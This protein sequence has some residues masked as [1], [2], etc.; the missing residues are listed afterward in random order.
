[1]QSLIFISKKLRK[2]LKI[3]HFNLLINFKVSGGGG[4]EHSDEVSYEIVETLGGKKH[5]GKMHKKKKHKKGYKKY[6]KNAT[7]IILCIIAL[8]MLLQH[9]II[10]KLAALS[11]LST[12][13]S[14]ASFLLSSLLALKQMM[15]S[16][17]HEKS[18]SGGKLEVVHIPIRKKHPDFHDRDTEKP[19]Y[20]PLNYP[21]YVY[22]QTTLEYSDP[23]VQI[24]N[25]LNE[26]NEYYNKN[27]I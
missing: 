21:K 2:I 15:S 3:I 5:G 14:K 22:D 19:K 24:E 20:I 17:H 11:I 12:L 7:P 8:K 9:F 23:N 6:M 26:Y 13:L 1:M 4:H 10:K 16:G 25:T 27:S 18:D